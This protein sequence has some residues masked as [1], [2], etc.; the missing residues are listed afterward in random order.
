MSDKYLESSRIISKDRIEQE[1]D[2]ADLLGRRP[3]IEEKIEFADALRNEVIDRTQQGRDV[4]NKPF[5]RYTEAYADF[6][7][8]SENDVDLTLFGLM[9]G[10][11]ETEIRGDSVVLKMESRQAPKAHGNITGS[12]GQPSPNNDKA[13]D[14]F[15]MRYSD[16]QKLAN[17]IK[18]VT[19]QDDLMAILGS[20][21]PPNTITPFEALDIAAI[22]S[23]IGLFGDES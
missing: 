7:G 8:V 11:M 12:Y 3:T 10:G 13:R 16:A 23:T 14:F 15:G 17:Q 6:K 1:I 2:L 18:R 22:L 21:P 4:H 9:L 20:A 19:E 5:E